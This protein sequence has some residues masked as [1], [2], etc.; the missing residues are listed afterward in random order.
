MRPA[1]LTVSL[2]LVELDLVFFQ[3]LQA[4][5]IAAISKSARATSCEISGKT[6]E[7]FWLV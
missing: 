4:D 2:S 1:F 6:Y 3:S 7:I 5:R